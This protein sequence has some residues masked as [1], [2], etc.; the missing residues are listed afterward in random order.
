[1]NTTEQFAFKILL[2]FRVTFTLAV[3][4]GLTVNGDND[5]RGH[6]SV[7]TRQVLAT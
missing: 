7:V 4:N 3:V 6:W 5:G 1:M 2:N